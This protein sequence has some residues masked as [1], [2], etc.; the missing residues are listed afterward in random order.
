MKKSFKINSRHEALKALI[1]QHPVDNQ[2][3][4]VKLLKQEYN[5]E[6]NQAIISRD[7]RDLRITKKLL[8]GKL[9]YENSNVDVTQEILNASIIDIVYNEAMIVVKTLPGLADYVGDYID[10]QENSV[11]LGTL[12]GENVVFITPWSVQNIKYTFQQVCSMLGF[13][14]LSNKT[15]EV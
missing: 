15:K 6:A 5:I 13:K 14:P 11:I 2:Q 10:S 4:L 1:A 8:N 12:A 7:L 9:V 3:K